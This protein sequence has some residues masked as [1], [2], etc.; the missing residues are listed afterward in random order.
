MLVCEGRVARADE[1]SS[2]NLYNFAAWLLLLDGYT[3]SVEYLQPCV[4]SHD[5]FCM[6]TSLVLVQHMLTT[7]VTLTLLYKWDYIS[8]TMCCGYVLVRDEVNT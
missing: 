5:L 3:I 8:C 2:H 6:F 1:G 4:K 7:H